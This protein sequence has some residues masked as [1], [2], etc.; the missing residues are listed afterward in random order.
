[1]AQDTGRKLTESEG[2]APR[3]Y[4]AALAAVPMQAKQ[5]GVQNHQRRIRLEDER[6][7]YSPTSGSRW[8]RL[9]LSAIPPEALPSYLSAGMENRAERRKCRYQR[10]DP[11]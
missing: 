3:L 10:S 11:E 2:A 9:L 4:Q 6:K 8:S 7:G 5:R 1:M